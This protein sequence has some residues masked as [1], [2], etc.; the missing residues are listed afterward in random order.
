MSDD[1]NNSLTS[2]ARG[3]GIIF[4]GMLIGNV[5]GILNQIIL[6]RLMGPEIYGIYNLALSVVTIASTLAVFGFFGSLARFIPFHL[7]KGEGDKVRS[8]IDFSSIFVLSTGIIFAVSIQ[9]LAER[10]AVGVFK[11]HELVTPLRIFAAGIPVLGLQTV[12]RG[13][14]RG[15]K[16]VR[17][18]VI[19]F[20]IGDR[21]IKIV[22]FLMSLT[23]VSRLYGAIAAHITVAVITII[24][25]MW[26]I[27]HRIFPDYRKLSRTPVAKEM[28]SFSWPL[29]L[30]GFTFLFVSKTDKVLLGYFLD[31]KD[32]GIYSPALVI[33]GLLIFVATAFKFM[34]L[35]TVSEYFARK[36]TSGLE[37]LFKSTSKWIFLIV[38]PLFLLILLFPREVIRFLYGVKYTEGY[39]ALIILSM[40]I[41]LNDFAGTAGNILVGGGHTK[42]NLVCEVIAAVTNII[43]NI[44][45]IPRFGIVG[46]AAATG[47][48]YTTRNISSLSFVYATHRMH[49][50]KANYLSILLSGLI[51][52]GIIYVLKMYSPFSWLIN[53]LV[54]SVIFILIF[55][56]LAVIMRSFDQNDRVVLEA[57]ERKSG[58]NL[59]FIKKFI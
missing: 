30:T 50:Y 12:M 32:V 5:L 53:M 2:V 45:L 8:T 21:V 1:F 36:D 17:Y 38:L 26:L 58:I 57:I 47:I 40:G 44:I 59:G 11:E 10:I 33:A 22:L 52:A 31:S 27:R 54:L 23:F 7:E 4:T 51:T 34:F 48:S 14:T 25:T 46:A 13:I 3:A 41:A 20:N 6:G 55:L 37:M 16:A 28:L 39:L 15:F 9:F 18:N 56:V 42:L 29:A 19:I 49:P 24:A 35:P 43:L